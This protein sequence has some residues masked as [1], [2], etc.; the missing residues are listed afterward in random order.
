MNID[1]EIIKDLIGLAKL[2]VGLIGLIVYVRHSSEIGGI[3]LKDLA[4]LSG[5]VGSGIIG[6][7]IYKKFWS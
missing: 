4:D 7:A 3:E 6:H 2:I 5:P 1:K